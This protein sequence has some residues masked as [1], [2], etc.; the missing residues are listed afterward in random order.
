M[1][2]KR[3]TIKTIYWDG[4]LQRILGVPVRDP[5]PV[6]LAEDPPPTALSNITA[7]SEQPDQSLATLSE[8]K[9]AARESLGQNEPVAEENQRKR[10]RKRTPSVEPTEPVV[11][12]PDEPPETL[13]RVPDDE[14]AADDTR[15]GMQPKKR[16]ERRVEITFVSDDEA[17][18]GVDMVTKVVSVTTTDDSSASEDESDMAISSEIEG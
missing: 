14:D 8:S 3:A 18:D 11:A 10:K 15:Y 12:P 7:A 4:V 13:N 9:A 1:Y 6:P 2:Q 16:R 5:P 17:S